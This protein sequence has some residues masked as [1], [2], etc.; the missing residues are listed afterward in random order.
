[1]RLFFKPSLADT[2]V[3]THVSDNKTPPQVA[4]NKNKIVEEDSSGSSQVSGSS[5]SFEGVHGVDT[6]LKM[7]KISPNYTKEIELIPSIVDS[8]TH[9]QESLESLKKLKTS[10]SDP[11]STNV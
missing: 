9:K 7:G 3:P 10:F 6:L 8:Y 11:V 1:M 5:E 4:L 2:Q